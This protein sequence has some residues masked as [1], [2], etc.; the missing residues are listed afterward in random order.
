MVIF[1]FP[2]ESNVDA[3]RPDMQSPEPELL[4]YRGAE[5]QE[6]LLER[7]AEEMPVSSWD[8]TVR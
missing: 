7:R 2:A 4:Y 8:S 5:D 6:S 3:L 1:D